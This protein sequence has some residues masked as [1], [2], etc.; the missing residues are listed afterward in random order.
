MGEKMTPCSQENLVVDKQKRRNLR[1]TFAFKILDLERSEE[2]WGRVGKSGYMDPGSEP[3][4]LTRLS[5]R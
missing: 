3:H 2:E 5:P 1:K 4:S